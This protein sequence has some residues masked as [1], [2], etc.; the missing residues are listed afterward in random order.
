[1][2]LTVKLAAGMILALTLRPALAQMPGTSTV[3][4]GTQNPALAQPRLNPPPAGQPTQPAPEQPAAAPQRDAA[5]RGSMIIPGG[6][7]G[8]CECLVNH[9][10][11]V[12][13]LDITKMHQTCL[14]SVDACQ[15]ACNT[16]H[17]YSFVPH[18][19]NTCPTRPGEETGGHIAMN[20]RATIWL[21]SRR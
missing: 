1:M 7:A 5:S 14:A 11:A 21:L 19:V 10:P 3:P 4:A 18:A 8:L 20:T 16:D 13:V 12:P 15:A 2:K 17:Y 6:A 9:D